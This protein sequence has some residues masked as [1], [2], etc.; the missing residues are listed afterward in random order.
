ME[1]KQQKNTGIC[2][3]RKFDRLGLHESFLRCLEH[4]KMVG[5][6]VSLAF[7]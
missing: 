7:C 5:F 4:E 1:T 6:V 3:N 2:P